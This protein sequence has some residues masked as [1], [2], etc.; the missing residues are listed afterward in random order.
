MSDGCGAQFK[1]QFCV[2]D[3]CEAGGRVLGKP[4]AKVSFIYFESNEGKGESD[5]HGLVEKMQI[6][7]MVLCDRS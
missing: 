3:F 6:E 4:G 2:A 5:A 7:R 1:S